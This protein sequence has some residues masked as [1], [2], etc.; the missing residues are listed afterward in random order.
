MGITVTATSIQPKDIT[1]SETGEKVTVTDSTATVTNIVKDTLTLTLAGANTNLG[2]LANVEITSVADGQLLVYENSSGKWKNSASSTGVTSVNSLTGAVVLDTDDIAEDGSPTN[3]Y[4]TDAR[5]RGVVSATDAGGDGSFAYNSGTGVFTYTGPTASETRAHFTAGSGLTLASGEYSIGNDAIKDTMIDFGTGAT[6]VSTADVPEQTNLYYT[7]TRVQ[8]KIDA[9]SA[10]FITAS[11]TETLTNKSGAVSMF[12]N[13][14]G[15]LTSETDSQTLSFSSPD[16]SISGGNSVD[17]SALTSGF[18]TATSTNTLTNKTLTSPVLGG[19]T[20]TASGNI[21]VKPATNILEVQGDDSSVVGQIQLN[22]H[23]NTHGQ[24][25]A[26]QPHSQA[27]TNKLT[28]PGGTAIGNGDATLVSDTGTQTLTNK[29]L[30]SPVISSISNTGTVTLPTSTDTLVGKATTDTLTNKTIDA[31]GTGNSITNLEV[32]DL[33]SGVL[34]T[35]LSSVSGSDDTLASAKAIKTYVDATATGITS[36]VQDTTPQLGGD[37]D[38]NGQSI[39][40][41]SNGNI[42]MD[43][44][45]T[46]AVTIEGDST[47]AGNFAA[48]LS[49]LA[50]PPLVIDN[51]QSNAWWGSQMIMKDNSDDIFAMVGREDTSN[52]V[53]GYIIT[54]DP[55]GTHTNSSAYAGDYGYYFNMQYEGGSGSDEWY[56]IH[57]VYGADDGY[58]INSFGSG[59]NSYARTPLILNGSLTVG[60]TDV[61]LKGLKLTDST[62]SVTVQDNMTVNLDRGGT[63]ALV[64]EN[65]SAT[66]NGNRITVGKSD[67]AHTSGVGFEVRRGTGSGFETQFKVETATSRTRTTVTSAFNLAPVAYASLHGDPSIGDLQFLT[68]D[69][70]GASKNAPIYYDGSNWKYF[71]DNSTVA[72]S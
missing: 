33:A 12:T 9:N 60:T 66:A 10:G 29:T 72:P 71:N 30:T 20:T 48:R 70:A 6:Q 37:L 65:E 17:I 2:D 50:N 26:A 16:L 41:T 38:V 22:C 28:L 1:I 54:M 63:T 27:A 52:K 42:V 32:A 15:Y 69:G 7:D 57:N 39:V 47:V 59:H 25:I 8:T 43:P 4:F 24:K 49:R 53:Y 61:N 21:V 34:D 68:T 51:N 35:D 13:D 18:I 14:A 56:M 45:G 11:S 62:G 36:V 58:F 40:S 44:N 67:T 3:R 31:N 64:T 55:N 5:A 23:A 19:T 46:G